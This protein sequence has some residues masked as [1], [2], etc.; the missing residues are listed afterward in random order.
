MEV[1]WPSNRTLL[2]FKQAMT[3][4]D[5]TET[6]EKLEQRLEEHSKGKEKESS[7]EWAPQEESVEGEK[8][9]NKTL[10]Q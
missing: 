5:S 8:E 6:K 2:Y 1:L 10:N 4:P 3:L 7:D 9:K